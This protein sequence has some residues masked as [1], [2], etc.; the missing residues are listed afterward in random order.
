MNPAIELLKRLGQR[1]ANIVGTVVAVEGQAVKVRTSRGLVDARSVDA[2]TY[3]PGDEVLL[4]D[5]I[6]QGRIKQASEVPVY[7]V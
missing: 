3:R 7:F 6:V 2:T 5:G 1:P 4:R